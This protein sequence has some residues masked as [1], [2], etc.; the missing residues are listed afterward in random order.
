[1]LRRHSWLVSAVCVIVLL[2][3]MG[4]LLA[5]NWA[6]VERI[7]RLRRMSLAVPPSETLRGI[8]AAGPVIAPTSDQSRHLL[9]FVIR[10]QDGEADRTLW[11]GVIEA[12]GHL[13]KKVNFWA[14]CDAGNACDH[15]QARA[16]FQV[17]GFL[18]AYGMHTVA[19]ADSKAAALLYGPR[20]QLLGLVKRTREPLAIAQQ[21]RRL[22]R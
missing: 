6:E 5:L 12:L 14:V 11:N 22:I 18:D 2:G 3:A 16:R 21:V 13:G 15:L 7:S 4:R 8:S 17:V 10:S 1:M 19:N 9:V 20:G